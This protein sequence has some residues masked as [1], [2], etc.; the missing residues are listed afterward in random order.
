MPPFLLQSHR[1]RI[2]R[3]LQL[4]SS[5]R[6][7]SSWCTAEISRQVPTQ[8][9][10][11]TADVFFQESKTSRVYQKKKTATR[12]RLS[13]CVLPLWKKH[14]FLQ[15]VIFCIFSSYANNIAILV[16]HCHVDTRRAIQSRKRSKRGKGKKNNEQARARK[17]ILKTH[18][19]TK[20]NKHLGQPG[21]KAKPR[22]TKR[23]K[24]KD[25]EKRNRT[26]PETGHNRPE[27]TTKITQT[28]HNS[29]SPT[30]KSWIDSTPS[31]AP[32]M[33]DASTTPIILPTRPAPLT[34]EY[35]TTS[36]GEGVELDE[37]QTGQ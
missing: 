10:N 13:V 2:P 28:S 11:H 1:S 23:K 26:K 3:N 9:G 7:V 19:K 36:I 15:C 16:Q 6:R 37:I 8:S 24:K 32:S 25:K 30:T 22:A 27:E 14:V 29:R 33:V 5:T 12:E 4:S 20:E 17:S 34:K 35:L 21:P 31:H 18:G